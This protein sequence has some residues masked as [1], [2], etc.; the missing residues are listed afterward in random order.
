MIILFVVISTITTVLS[1]RLSSEYIGNILR[2]V[3][4]TELYLTII[5]SQ[6]HYMTGK[7]VE[8]P[9]LPIMEFTFEL[10]T[11]LKPYDIRSFLG[12]EIPGFYA[13]DTQFYVAG[14]GTDYTDIPFESVAPM[15]VLL[16]EREI[17]EEMLLAD[18][19]ENEQAPAPEKSMDET[20]VHIYQSH[21]WES[22]LPLL[23]NVNNPNDATSNN[24]DVNV[25]A[26]GKMLKEELGDKGIKANH[27]T[28]NVPQD[29]QARGWDANQSYKYS[30]ETVE[31]A[32]VF[33]NDVKYL[34]DI[35]RD[36]ARKDKTTEEIGGKKYARLMF[37]VGTAHKGYEQNLEFAERIH[38]EIEEKYPGLSRGVFPKGKS[39][40]NGLYNQDLSNRAI[41]LEVGGVDNNLEEARNSIKAFAD[42]YSEIVWEEREAGEF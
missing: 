21:S 28:R 29:L 11:N 26:V 1:T 2:N 31:A 9:N 24:P 27:D 18:E 4:S 17:A 34:I 16:K 10:A 39:T 35:H 6:N 33:N 36:S 5:Q 22:Y 38:N 40:G 42:I 7:D 25:I 3:Q 14:K 32:M 13:Y 41:L 20:I 15:E 23:K 12:N 19:K 8:V 37:V 30:R